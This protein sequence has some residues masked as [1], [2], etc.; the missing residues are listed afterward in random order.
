MGFSGTVKKPL[1]KSPITKVDA[2]YFFHTLDGNALDPTLYNAG[3]HSIVSLKLE[4]RWHP[5]IFKEYFVRSGL[6]MSEGFV[7]SN[8]NSGFTYR[9]A[10]KLKTSLY[11]GVGLFLKS[12]NIPEQYRYYLSGTVDPDFEQIVIDRTKTSSGFKV[13]YNT[14]YGSGVR[15]II[16]DNPLLSSDNLFWHVRIDQSIP[17]LPGNLFL[18]IAGAPD[19]EES[20]YVSTGFT[21][22][23]I[24]IPLYQS[25]EMESKVPN[26]FDW[27]KNRFRIAL[28]FPNIT[29]GR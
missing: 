15:G 27:I 7:K 4:K 18:D 28:V 2:D 10:N 26:N 12:E 21:L 16:I 9:V 22:G 3:N 19:F 24:I 17:I 8:L 5:S 20:K 11:A 6:K 1:T 25:W 29:F 13:L 23:P 14:Y